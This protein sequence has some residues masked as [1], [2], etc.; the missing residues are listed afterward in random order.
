MME[1]EIELNLILFRVK[2]KFPAT[3]KQ[4]SRCSDADDRTLSRSA[5]D[6]EFFKMNNDTNTRRPFT[7]TKS[8][9]ALNF[10]SELENNVAADEI[11]DDD[12]YCLP[13]VAE[14]VEYDTVS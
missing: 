14:V 11:E 12:F 2:I 8:Y 3:S 13:H 9:A 10:I 1:R 4:S 6:W 5:S 7:L